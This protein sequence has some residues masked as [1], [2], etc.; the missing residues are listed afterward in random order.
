MLASASG[1]RRRPVVAAP[2][3]Q[4]HATAASP[5]STPLGSLWSVLDFPGNN[6]LTAPVAM[7]ARSSAWRPVFFSLSRRWPRTAWI[8][9]V[10]CPLKVG[11]SELL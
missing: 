6:L 5:Q 4:G 2:P 9:N 7:F 3:P 11:T 1:Y 8:A 10:L